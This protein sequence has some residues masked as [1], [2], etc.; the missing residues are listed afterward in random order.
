MS[1]VLA[2]FADGCVLSMFVVSAEESELRSM[3]GNEDISAEES[4]TISFPLPLQGI[5]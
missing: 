3:Q 5:K 4:R 1:T 2:A